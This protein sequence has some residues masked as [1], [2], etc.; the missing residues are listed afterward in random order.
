MTKDSIAEMFTHHALNRDQL[1]RCEAIRKKAQA[2]AETIL[3]VTKQSADQTAS[4]RK[5]RECMMTANASIAM[6]CAPE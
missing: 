5:L 2:L 3:R 1:N 4:I 6:E